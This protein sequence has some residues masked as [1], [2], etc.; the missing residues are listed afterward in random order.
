MLDR[1]LPSDAEVLDPMDWLGGKEPSRASRYEQWNEDENLLALLPKPKRRSARSVLQGRSR[2]RPPADDSL[3]PLA[4]E[5][6]PRRSDRETV[7]YRVGPGD[8]LLGVARQFVVD[9]E[10]L[11]TDNGLDVDAKLR[12]G[13]LLKLMVKREVLDRWSTKRSGGRH[14][15][16]TVESSKDARPTLRKKSAKKGA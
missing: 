13:A 15:G 14:K 2:I 11:A 9:I 8:T 7:M 12:E 1:R 5:F 4:K 10:D 16:G 3:A 6:G